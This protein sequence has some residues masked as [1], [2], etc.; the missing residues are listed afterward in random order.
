MPKEALQAWA[1]AYALAMQAVNQAVQ[2]GTPEGIGAAVHDLLLLP[3]AAF[4]S[5]DN[6]RTTG[7]KANTSLE[8]LAANAQPEEDEEERSAAQGR[9]QRLA[10]I[11]G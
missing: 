3:G 5:A 4:S 2:Q 10:E 8:R 7:K 1:E 11:L 6:G 9:R